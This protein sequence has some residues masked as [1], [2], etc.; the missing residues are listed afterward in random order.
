MPDTCSSGLVDDLL[1]A[2]SLLTV[3]RA[4]QDS[5]LPGHCIHRAD[6]DRHSTALVRATPPGWRRW[7]T[8][9]GRQTP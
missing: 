5:E 1:A 7:T 6:S 4:T 2:H 8:P 9:D 3:P